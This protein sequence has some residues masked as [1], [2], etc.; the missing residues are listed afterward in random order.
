[1]AFL[2][3]FIDPTA[4]FGPLPFFILGGTFLL[5]G[6]IWCS[7]IAIG[8]SA[9]ADAVRNNLKIQRGFDLVVSLLYSGLGA[10]ILV[11]HLAQL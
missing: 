9:F 5:I 2:P 4:G 8:A 1:L 11:I 10:A 7:I 6:T 3:G